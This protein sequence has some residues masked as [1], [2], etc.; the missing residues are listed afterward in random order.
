MAIQPQ[1]ENPKVHPEGQKLLESIKKHLPALHSLL[2]AQSRYSLGEDEFYRFYHQSFKVYGLQ[3]K[4]LQILQLFAEVGRDAG[5]DHLNPLFSQII[6]AGTGHTFHYSHNQDWST[7]T[8][9]ILEAFFHSREM[10]SLMVKY[11]SE[12][13]YAPNSL[14]SGWGAIL[15]LYQ[16]R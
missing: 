10:L 4:T 5:F 11:G 15:Y 7:H 8:R 6:Q 9:P 3:T 14:P 13:D 1:F 16:I 2:R 12:L